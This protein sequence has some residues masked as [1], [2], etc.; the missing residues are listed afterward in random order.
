MASFH[1]KIGWKGQRKRENKNYR[2]VSFLPDGQEKIPK[3]QKKIQKLKNTFTASLQA[4][5]C[6]KRLRKRE[7]KNYRSVSFLPD[8]QEKIPKKQQKNSKN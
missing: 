7:N 3:K 4:K 2:S 1:G 8:G 5:I 6:W